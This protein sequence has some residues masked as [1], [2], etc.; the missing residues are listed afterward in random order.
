MKEPQDE[1]EN[2][3]VAKVEDDEVE[4]DEV[5][6]VEPYVYKPKEETSARIP[7]T[8]PEPLMDS[9]KY[10]VEIRFRAHIFFW[11]KNMKDDVL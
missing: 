2:N 10:A 7:G 4:K 6:K 5:A 1:P 11:E 3:V 8:S 9:H